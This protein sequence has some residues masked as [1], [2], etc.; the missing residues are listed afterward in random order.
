MAA[1]AVIMRADLVTWARAVKAEVDPEG[2][3]KN[4]KPDSYWMEKFMER[5]AIDL[6]AQTVTAVVAA[7][8]NGNGNTTRNGN[9]RHQRHCASSN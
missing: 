8:E 4:F 7:N 1:G 6:E 2:N 3:L 9:S 5:H